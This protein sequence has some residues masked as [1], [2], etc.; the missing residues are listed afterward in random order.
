[1]NLRNDGELSFENAREPEYDS[2]T[3]GTVFLPL[4]GSEKAERRRSSKEIA[5]S[6]R[7]YD[8][9]EELSGTTSGTT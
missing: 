5:R 7:E 9:L 2:F 1:M 8:S 6:T 3:F 4:I